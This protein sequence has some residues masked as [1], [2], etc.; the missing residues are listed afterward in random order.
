MPDALQNVS[1][2]VYD[3]NDPL[4]TDSQVI[5]DCLSFASIFDYRTIVFD[6][7]DWY[8]DEAILLPSNTTVRI[9]NVRI[10]QNDYVFDNVFRGDNLT[11]DEAN[12]D[13]YPKRISELH[14]IKIVG[15]G[16]ATIEGPDV[17]AQYT[18]PVEGLQD[19]VGDY[20]GWRTLQVSF[21]KIKQI[22][23]CGIAFAKTRC[24]AISLDKCADFSIHDLSIV[25]DVKNGD[26][27]D[28]RF[29]CHDFEIYN[30]EGSTS[31]DSVA[32]TTIDYF[33]SGKYI[34]PM[35]PSAFE[36]SDLTPEQLSIYNGKVKNIRTTG[37]HH[38]VICLANSGRQVHHI[39]IDGIIE[40]TPSTRESVVKLYAGYGSG[41]REDNIHT[42]RINDVLSKGA[43]YAVQVAAKVEDVWF[44]KVVQHNENGSLHRIEH[45]SGI[46]ITNS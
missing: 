45:P 26:G 24:W 32:M 15:S 10:K 34:F 5:R 14:N 9:D 7:K 3:F 13:H 1:I 29:G 16:S 8:I 36:N 18:H 44:N 2:R 27:V 46:R 4:K 23:I 11:I 22:E 43:S 37:N 40:P 17:N 41:Y 39:L 35:E 25:S 20:Y 28:V 6:T 33:P 30:I 19:K 21:S 31:D 38:G 12:P 42:I